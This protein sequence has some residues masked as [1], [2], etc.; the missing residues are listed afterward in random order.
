LSM[1][2]R[3]IQIDVMVLSWVDMVDTSKMPDSTRV[4][5]FMDLGT[6]ESGWQPSVA[7]LLG[8]RV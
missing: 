2:K 7:L 6:P 1:S 5:E 4:S 3:P 8:A